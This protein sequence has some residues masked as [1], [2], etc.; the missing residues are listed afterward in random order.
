MR[1]SLR[2]IQLVIVILLNMSPGS[3]Q[4]P[5]KDT[6]QIPIQS[7]PELATSPS[8]EEMETVITSKS[9]GMKLVLIPAETF[10]MCSSSSELDTA[11]KADKHFDEYAAE[12]ETHH[13]VKISRP[14]YMGVHEVTQRQFELVVGTNPSYFSEHGEGSDDVRYV[15][16]QKL[17]VEQVT[18]GDALD[19]CRMLSE[20]DGI[21]YRLPTEAEWEYACRGGS[22][23]VVAQDRNDRRTGSDSSVAE[24]PS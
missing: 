8:G 13:H 1:S 23:S 18:W 5:I 12:G 21:H 7:T 3:G 22:R 14:F 4:V 17:P 19:F 20:R 10:L 15:D 11:R 16:T 9:T 24:T 2:E 6:V